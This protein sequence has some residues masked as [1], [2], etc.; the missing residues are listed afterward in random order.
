MKNGKV[1]AKNCTSD[2]KVD[3]L[4]KRLFFFDETVERRMYSGIEVG[5]RGGESHFEQ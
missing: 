3:F 1:T 4:V 5:Q 2:K